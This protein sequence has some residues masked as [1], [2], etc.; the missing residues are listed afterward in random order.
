M[1]CHCS[2]KIYWLKQ[3]EEG[4][5]SNSWSTRFL[6]CD[7]SVEF[8]F[9]VLFLICSGFSWSLAYVHGYMSG[10]GREGEKPIWAGKIAS[11]VPWKAS[12][13]LLGPCCHRQLFSPVTGWEKGSNEGHIQAF[14]DSQPSIPYGKMEFLPCNLSGAIR[15]H[16]LPN[17]SSCIMNN[18][19]ESPSAVS[20]PVCWA[21][22]VLFECH[23]NKQMGHFLFSCTLCHFK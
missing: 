13:L 1:D 20:W 17:Y 21:H 2:R 15:R 8:C 3:K 16:F 10:I 14:S 18:C 6:K 9:M 11:G 22:S 7:L 19:T 23:I 4:K 12:G 5:S